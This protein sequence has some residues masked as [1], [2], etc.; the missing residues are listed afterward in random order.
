MVSTAALLNTRNKKYSSK[1]PVDVLAV[2]ISTVFYL[3]FALCFMSGPETFPTYQ[4]QID[5]VSLSSRK[6][7]LNIP[8]RLRSREKS[9][10]FFFYSSR[11]G[12]RN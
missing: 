4:R 9:I 8:G 3:L 11:E 6:P 12:L 7:P 2:K 10:Q 1:E 5:S